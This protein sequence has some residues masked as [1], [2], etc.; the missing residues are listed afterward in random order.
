MAPVQK[1]ERERGMFVLLHKVALHVGQAA[2]DGNHQ[3][4][5]ACGG[6]G[7]RLGHRAELRAR[8]H[9]ALDD[10]EAPLF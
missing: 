6:V 2:E 3:A 10:G 7:P 4:A 1:H 8:V 9:D 5:G